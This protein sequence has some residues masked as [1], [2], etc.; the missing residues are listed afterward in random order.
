[1]SNNGET[2]V[3]NELLKNERTKVPPFSEWAVTGRDLYH[4][5]LAPAPA[6]PWPIFLS[7]DFYNSLF[8]ESESEDIKCS[9]EDRLNRTIF[10]K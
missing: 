2:Y 6:S 8:P 9:T 1:M 4:G 5:V 10:I 7:S 3:Y